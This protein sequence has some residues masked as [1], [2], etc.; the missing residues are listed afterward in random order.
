[1]KKISYKYLQSLFK[2]C[3]LTLLLVGESHADM[4]GFPDDLLSQ[5]SQIRGELSLVYGNGQ[6]YNCDDMLAVF[7]VN[8]SPVC[9]RTSYDSLGISPGIRYGISSKT[10]LYTHFTWYGVTTKN[11]SLFDS[12]FKYGESHNRFNDIWV[13]INH[14]IYDEGE[15]PGFIV[16]LESALVENSTVESDMQN[17]V[18]GQSWMGGFTL[19]RTSDPMILSLTSS[20]RYSFKRKL[21]LGGQSV[22]YT[23]GS[24]FLINP[25]VSF[26]ANHEISLTTGFQWQ[27][28]EG[29]S[30]ADTQYDS[31]TRTDLNLGVGYM[32]SDETTLHVSTSTDMTGDGGSTVSMM[33]LYIF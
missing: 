29:N 20:Y 16:F 6:Y 10:E 32:W 19:Y 14:R 27:Y 8:G 13:G 28:Q 1:M 12:S 25:S 15:K 11:Q 17:F 9:N 21:N 26:A 24:S 2:S 22:D 31:S 5:S 7:D 3:A 18:Y 30:V 33:L 23:P 4:I